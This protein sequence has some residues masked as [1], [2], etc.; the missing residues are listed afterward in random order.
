MAGAGILAATALALVLVFVVF[1]GDRGGGSG[2]EETV[3]AFF[4]ALEREDAEMLLDTM[5]P[6][7]REELEEALGDHQERFF[8]LFFATV[9]DD[10]KV[11]IR[12]TTTDLRGEEATVTVTE[13]TLSYTDKNGE[14]VAE[15]ASMAG[16]SSFE[17]VRVGAKWYISGDYLEEMGF[18]LDMLDYLDLLDELGSDDGELDRL[19]P[20]EASLDEEVLAEVEAAMLDYVYANAE[21]GLEFAITGIMVNGSEAV[22]IAVCLN[23]E[24]ENVPVVMGRGVSGWYGVDLGTGIELPDWFL[25]EMAEV[26]EVM[27]DFAYL[28]SSGDMTLEITRLAIRGDEAV[29]VVTSADHEVESAAITAKKGSRGWYV[30]DFGTGID[31]PEWYWPQAYW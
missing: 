2:P 17:L 1:G 4:R 25:T 30:E 19:Y 29:A 8:E 12:E 9:P 16:E 24:L 21:E 31:V 20:P 18:D 28:N 22:G 10:L 13:G 27:L 26:E 3:K 15:E 14:K 7:F 5:E 11:D 6:S 23:Q